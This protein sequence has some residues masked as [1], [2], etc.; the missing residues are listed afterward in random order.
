[1]TL[2]LFFTSDFHGSEICW[3]KFLR[4][5]ER[6]K[7]DITILGGDLTGKMIIPIVAHRNGTHSYTLFSQTNFIQNERE[8]PD[9]IEK[10][11][12]YGYY[13]YLCSEE[14]VERLRENVNLLKA[15][16]RKLMR[17]RIE[18]WVS[19]AEERM[20]EA[21]VRMFMSPGNDDDFVIDD[22]IMRSKVIT[23]S[24]RRLVEV[25]DKYTM[26]TLGWVNKTPWNTP[27]ETSD[28]GLKN[29]LEELF[30]QVSDCRYLICNFHAPPYNTGLD[31][32]PKLDSTLS[33]KIRPGGGVE[34]V[35]V[36]SKAVRE[37]LERYQPL[38][39]LHGH[40]H[41]SSGFRR[42]KRT[43]C[44]NPGSEYAEGILRGFIVHLE[45]DKVAGYWRVYG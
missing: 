7:V 36:G 45:K 34:V 20:R 39:G 41:E 30:A 24:E 14:E 1:M 12:G 4:V 19:M 35:P 22:A 27:R 33:I 17:E 18:R 9:I 6:Y 21:G 37:A 2:K 42:L 11:A 5:F 28:E 25:G 13:S 31:L 15:S 43:L 40:I 8:I 32:A 44:V 26:I 3:R 10:I 38:L 16:F 23:Y 29:M